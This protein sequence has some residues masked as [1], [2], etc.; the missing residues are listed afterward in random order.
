[1]TIPLN[2][3]MK[4][5]RKPYHIIIIITTSIIFAYYYYYNFLFIIII[6]PI[7]IIIICL[8][9]WEQRVTDNYK[10]VI[11]QILIICKVVLR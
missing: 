11:I 8:L 7:I 5:L 9:P 6:I 4:E 2:Y 3:L 1:M 10:I